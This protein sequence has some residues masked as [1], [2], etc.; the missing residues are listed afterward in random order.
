MADKGFIAQLILII[1]MLCLAPGAAFARSGALVQSTSPSFTSSPLFVQL[2][3]DGHPLESLS[4]SH[5]FVTEHRRLAST[6]HP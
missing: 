2:L 3:F 4:M 6:C 5:N 1:M